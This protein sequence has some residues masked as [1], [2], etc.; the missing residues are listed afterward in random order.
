[1]SRITQVSYGETVSKDYQSRKLEMV[2]TVEDDEDPIAV[3]RAL[4]STVRKTLGIG[5]SQTD[6]DAAIKTL[7]DAG[8]VSHVGPQQGRTVA[9]KAKHVTPAKAPEQPEAPED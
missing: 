2:A 4:R 5:P 1:V 9:Q 3:Y 8:M 6:I 7:D